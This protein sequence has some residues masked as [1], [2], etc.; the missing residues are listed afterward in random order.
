VKESA[1]FRDGFWGALTAVCVA[2]AVLNYL[3][4]STTTGRIVGT[5]I[6]GLL[7]VLVALAWYRVRRAPARLEISDEAITQFNATSKGP[8]LLR[9]EGSDLMFVTRGSA[10]YRYVVLM[11]RGA[12]TELPLRYF[13]RKKIEQ[14]GRD[15]GWSFTTGRTR[16]T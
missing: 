3:N 12:P 2:P 15:H 7:A 5:V 14:A 11:A 9:T 10:R 4:A 13:R 16:G 8:A 6:F 1:A